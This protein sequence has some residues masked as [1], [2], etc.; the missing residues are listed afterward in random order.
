M[1]NLWVP[2]FLTVCIAALA[3]PE[4]ASP[5]PAGH[6]SFYCANGPHKPGLYLFAL[7][8]RPDK[9]IDFAVSLWWPDGNNFSVDGVA[10]P[11]GNGWRY[12]ASSADHC[13]ISITP[14]GRGY[15]LTIDQRAC[16][17]YGGHNAV[18]AQ[19]VFAG[20][21]RQGSAGSLLASPGA[22][23]NATCK[24]RP[25]KAPIPLKVKW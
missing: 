10:Q 17:S 11:S 3:W 15:S 14:D 16:E 9:D 25:S 13:V 5:Q 7:K 12:Q 20:S 6:D 21:M 24:A 22:F 19:V 1:K 23:A 8:E 2:I 18:P 4:A